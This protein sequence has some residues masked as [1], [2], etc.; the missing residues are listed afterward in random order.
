MPAALT[1]EPQSTLVL[2]LSQACSRDITVL[3]H[4]DI[5]M[6]FRSVLETLFS[7]L[8]QN[9]SAKLEVYN[10]DICMR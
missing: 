8:G 9:R 10:V 1:I 6:M 4:Q 5:R 2:K 7:F 3:Q